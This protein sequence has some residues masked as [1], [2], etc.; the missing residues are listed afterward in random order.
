MSTTTEGAMNNCMVC[1]LPVPA[2]E[3]RFKHETEIGMLQACSEECDIA[4]LATPEIYNVR[5]ADKE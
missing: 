4:Y 2:V 5:L 3:T 1:S